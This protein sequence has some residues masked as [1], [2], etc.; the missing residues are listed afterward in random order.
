MKSRD[1]AI[2]TTAQELFGRGVPQSRAKVVADYLAA[3]RTKGDAAPGAKVF[4]RECKS[5]HKIGEM[6]LRWDLT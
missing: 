4:E 2:A 1:K 5:C 6:G 3:I